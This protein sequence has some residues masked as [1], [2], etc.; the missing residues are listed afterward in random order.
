MPSVGILPGAFHGFD[1]VAPG[2][3]I[4]YQF[5]AASCDALRLAF[6]LVEMTDARCLSG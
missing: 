3:S 6:G 5:F 2:A 4:S 1:S